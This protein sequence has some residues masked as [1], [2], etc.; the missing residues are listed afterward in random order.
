MSVFPD[1]W[2]RSHLKGCQLRAEDG[3]IALG[4]A[5]GIGRGGEIELGWELSAVVLQHHR[6]GRSGS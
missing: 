6:G 4:A 2:V 3:L 1:N 5:A